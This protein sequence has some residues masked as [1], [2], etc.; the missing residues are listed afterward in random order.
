[1][2]RLIG[3]PG[4][5]WSLQR[6]VDALAE[7]ARTAGRPGWIWVAG[8]CYPSL[9]LTNQVLSLF[10][11]LLGEATDLPAPDLQL[12]F[13]PGSFFQ[14]GS[15]ESVVDALWL[16]PL[17]LV[18]GR[19][20]AGLAS[21]GGPDEWTAA[22]GLPST[23]KSPRLS[24]VW[25][26]GKGITLSAIGLWIAIQ[27][28]T[29][30]AVLMLLG[31]IVMLVNIFGL[32]EF[33]PGV[34]LLVSPVAVFLF[35]YV[36]VLQVMNQLALHSL[37]SNRRGVVSA[38]THA[39]RLIRHSPWAAVRGAAVDLLLSLTIALLGYVL[40]IGACITCVLAPILWAV[41]HFC[42]TG[43]TGV[44]RACYWARLYRDLGGL[45]PSDRVPGV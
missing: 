42:L 31:P 10:L 11:G 28:I 44:T 35:L 20:V 13:G 21:V 27:F 7:S 37:A 34:A 17:L 30:A 45:T 36:T 33:T 3:D 39:W 1:M 23:R 15:V 14:V 18:A 4:E 16:F 41:I 25:N 9:I 43:F 26:E 22:C 8:L 29:F 12:D 40:T 5:R 2:S 32:R 38:L 6:A 19:L 24:R